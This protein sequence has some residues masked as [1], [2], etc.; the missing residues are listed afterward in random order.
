MSIKLNFCWS[1]PPEFLR[2]FFHCK[3]REDMDL[4]R[5]KGAEEEREKVKV[6]REIQDMQER[7]LVAEEEKRRYSFDLPSLLSRPLYKLL[8]FQPGV[9]KG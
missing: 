7:K 4:W 8:V 3:M 6:E 9:W 2:S 1:V 5:E